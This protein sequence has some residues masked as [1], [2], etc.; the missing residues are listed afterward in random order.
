LDAD[1]ARIDVALALPTRRP[2]MPSAVLFRDEAID[3][4]FVIDD[5]V[6][7]DAR[8]RTVRRGSQ[9]LPRPRIIAC[10][11]LW[12]GEPAQC[13]VRILHAGIM[14]NDEI[15]GTRTRVIVRGRE[16][17][18]RKTHAALNLGRAGFTANAASA[19]PRPS[20]PACG[21]PRAFPHRR[22]PVAA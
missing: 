20:R 9:R 7:A 11:R 5:I 22:A 12:V 15:D 4:A 19:F 6:R 13:S 8:Q 3:R 16:V 17:D 14:K 1:G 10:N 21:A 18:A 2:R